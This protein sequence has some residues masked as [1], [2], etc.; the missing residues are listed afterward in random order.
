MPVDCKVGDWN[1]WGK[2]MGPSCGHARTRT[3]SRK[4]V[5]EAEHG[6]A[7]CPALEEK[8]A[9]KVLPCKPVNCRV[10]NWGAWGECHSQTGKKV[11]DSEPGTKTREREVVREP[12][13]GGA[14]CPDLRET[15]ECKGGLF[16]FL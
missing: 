6:G 10:L 1:T 14:A 4:V 16:P 11:G 5:R 12:K 8:M 2:C 13:K 9:C 3:R 15:D 7:A